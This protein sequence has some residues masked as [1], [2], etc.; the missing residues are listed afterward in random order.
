[1]KL[2]C[3]IVLILLLHSSLGEVREWTA[4]ALAKTINESE[5]IRPGYT[6][7]F[8]ELGFL[9]LI[10][11]SKVNEIIQKI[12]AQREVYTYIFLIG[13]MDLNS[14]LGEIE[15]FSD[16]LRE[17]IKVPSDL[18][19]E[20]MLLIVIDFEH[21]LFSIQ[22]GEKENKNMSNKD[23]ANIIHAGTSSFKQYA[24]S[25]GVY[26]I[27]EELNDFYFSFPTKTFIFLTI[28]WIIIFAL[29]LKVYFNKRKSILKMPYWFF[30]EEERHKLDI[31][32][33][34]FVKLD[35]N[36][37]L[38]DTHCLLCFHPLQKNATEIT[39]SDDTPN[40]IRNQMITE[41]Q[42]SNSIT[43]CDFKH[44][45][46]FECLEKWQKAANSSEC[47]ICL[48]EISKDLIVGKDFY[49]SKIRERLLS[50]QYD[51]IPN[52]G[53]FW[54]ISY[55]DWNDWGIYDF[56]GCTGKEEIVKKVPELKKI[57]EERLKRKQEEWERELKRKKKEEEEKI[58][59]EKEIEEM[60]KEEDE[61][62]E[63]D[64]NYIPNDD[65]YHYYYHPRR[66]HGSLFHFR[67][68]P[69]P[70]RPSHSS[71]YSPSQPSH[72]P[73]FSGYSGPK[74]G[75]FGGGSSGGASGGW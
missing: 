1:M 70:H 28:V 22:V 52:I 27:I 4:S 74:F 34:F 18:D 55:S 68:G 31:I 41:Q 15:L 16:K 56:L 11:K 71:H 13:K 63:K 5:E 48:Q 33:D 26:E 43:V 72:G 6:F 2:L 30:T 32:A 17:E 36:P 67:F 58:K 3:G 53:R 61:K 8:D 29:I 59:K 64:P 57:E 49:D 45:L 75:G 60:I 50:L 51:M 54:S 7:I 24:Y 35:T 66:Y 10:H 42:N 65:Y 21:R 62:R 14:C 9:T 25:K 23:A 73:S 37:N 40:D 69:P 19:K 12:S 38:L 44:A 20:K 46:H 47:P 39:V